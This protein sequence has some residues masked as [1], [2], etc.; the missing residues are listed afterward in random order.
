MKQILIS[1][2]V[3][4]SAGSMAGCGSATNSSVKADVS[5]EEARRFEA[6]FRPSEFDPDPKAILKSQDSNRQDST[7]RASEEPRDMME[8]VSG[9]RVQIFSSN[10]ID[11]A[12]AARETA[13]AQ[14]TQES[15]YLV[16]DPPTYKLR[17]G[18]FHTRYEA[19]RF[20]KQLRETG[21]R[22]AWVVPEKVY[23]IPQQRVPK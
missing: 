22:D 14:F 6:E 15:F 1:L 2:F 4:L 18:D 8:L 12:N 17:G 10:S 9:F 19:D 16:Y 21:Y 13:E 20:A 3:V 5:I 23:K 7:A 11:D